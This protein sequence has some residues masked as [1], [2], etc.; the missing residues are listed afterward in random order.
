MGYIID[1]EKWLKTEVTQI[2]GLT[3]AIDATTAG[4]RIP[5]N[6][7]DIESIARR[8]RKKFIDLKLDKD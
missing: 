5:Q 4:N 3:Y 7:K 8:A 2:R 6:L 1:R